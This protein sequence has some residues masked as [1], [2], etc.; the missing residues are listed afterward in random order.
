MARITK[1]ELIG[2]VWRQKA[3]Q[4]LWISKMREEIKAKYKNKKVEYNRIVFDSKKECARYRQLE[5][6]ERVWKIT[7]LKTQVV[8]VLVEKSKWQRALKYIADFEYIQD[9]KRIVEDVKGYKTQ[10]YNNKKKMLLSKYKD[11][12][13]FLET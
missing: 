10:V 6:L 1:D 3:E 12:F 7:D 5:I 2:I 11:E 8:F 9:G 4:L 13:I